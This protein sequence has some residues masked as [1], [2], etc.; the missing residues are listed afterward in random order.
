MFNQHVYPE[1]ESDTAVVHHELGHAF[2]WLSDGGIVDHIRF[3]RDRNGLLSGGMRQ[4]LPPSRPGETESA[5][6]ERM[7]NENSVQY[8][9]RLLAGEIAAR[10]FLN[11]P[12]DE[13]TCGFLI[14]RDSALMSLLPTI[15]LESSGIVKALHIAHDAAGDDWHPWIA[16]RHL[17][18]RERIERL[19]AGLESFTCDVLSILSS[20]VEN[21]LIIPG[22]DV[23][24]AFLV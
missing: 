21:Q 16:Q 22:R 19:W 3:W 13:I 23:R 2:V 14:T 15:E 8:A 11:L 6:L 17:E 20:Q 10:R 1:L 18:A 5:L 4:G 12:E 9:R 7:W 24:A